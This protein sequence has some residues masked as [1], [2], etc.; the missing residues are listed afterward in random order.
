[1][2]SYIESERPIDQQVLE[3]MAKKEVL[4]SFFSPE[5]VDEIDLAKKDGYEVTIGH[6]NDPAYEN[7]DSIREVFSM[8]DHDGKRYQSELGR[9][10][11]GSFAVLSKVRD[12]SIGSVSHWAKVRLKNRNIRANEI[13]SRIL[14][15]R[16][17][18][19]GSAWHD[20][21]GK[22]LALGTI[23]DAHDLKAIT[24]D[25]GVYETM[26]GRLTEDIV[27]HRFGE[28]AGWLS[29]MPLR[30]ALMNAE[31]KF[32]NMSGERVKENADNEM[33][34]LAEFV[35][36]PVRPGFKDIV[37]YC[38]DSLGIR[39]RKEEVRAEINRYVDESEKD[40][41]LM[42]SVGCGT[43]LPMLEVMGDLR[44]KQKECKLILIDQDPIAL[45]A[46]EQFAEQMGLSDAL[47]IHCSQLF[48]GKG[49]KTRLLDL[50]TILE[51]REVDVCEDSG[52]REYFPDFLY[53]D[54]TS[55]IWNS[56]AEDG[57]MTT[58]NMNEN[59]PQ[60]EFLDGLMG[61]PLKVK[62]RKIADIT[63]LH[64]KAGVPK[65]ASRL[66]VTQDGVYT[67]CFSSKK[68]AA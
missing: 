33:R 35:T 26:S 40:N 57:L 60:P 68:S 51:G 39:S 17:D 10:D 25:T 48:H 15:D 28:N 34:Q 6:T 16:L 61:W 30:D 31:I 12:A 29:G 49:R 18:V 55:Q 5:L 37:A 58:G 1:M 36:T 66:K 54:L 42:M 43:A 56:L 44:D 24:E 19:H 9:F 45:A 63:R 2:S 46:A 38:T 41:F 64:K 62:M 53:K 4:D 11:L 32:K 59:R 21:N 20:Q 14:Y 27:E 47:E 22:A 8:L 52:L 13:R 3:F 50:Q 7:P 23:V 65:S 67:L